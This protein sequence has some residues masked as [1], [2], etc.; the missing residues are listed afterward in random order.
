[1]SELH[2]R[3]IE[4]EILELLK[5][6]APMSTRQISEELNITSA[7]CLHNIEKLVEK[8]QISKLQASNSGKAYYLV[9]KEATIGDL[10]NMHIEVAKETVN[11]KDNYEDLEEK[12]AKV[13]RNVNGIYANIISIMSI[14]VCIFALITVNANIAFKLTQ[15]NMNNIFCGIITMNIFVVL[16]IVVLLISIRILIINPLVKKSENKKEKSK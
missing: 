3:D 2:Q 14:F 8:N 16:C 11:A 1:M 6:K 10:S 13:D 5:E 12:L 7:F 15:E 9:N 4:N